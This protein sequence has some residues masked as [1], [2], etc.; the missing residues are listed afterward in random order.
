M[1][2]GAG[3]TLGA[4]VR[5]EEHRESDKTRQIPVPLV[6]SPLGMANANASG[7]GSSAG[8]QNQAVP[9][10]TPI[11]PNQIEIRTQVS[12]TVAIS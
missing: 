11:V 8:P 10:N 9:A 1:A 7:R 6:R 12:V 5:I 3:R 2:S 4:I